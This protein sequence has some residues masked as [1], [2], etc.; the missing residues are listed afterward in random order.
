M[1]GKI[2]EK[3]KQFFLCKRKAKPID[4]LKNALLTHALTIIYANEFTKNNN[5]PYSS[6]NGNTLP[7]L[8]GSDFEMALFSYIANESDH[9]SNN[10]YSKQMQDKAIAINKFLDKNLDSDIKI[11][12]FFRQYLENLHV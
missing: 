12:L 8:S 3:I 2:W 9:T 5:Q 11:I 6:Y 4:K 7:L 1:C 10:F